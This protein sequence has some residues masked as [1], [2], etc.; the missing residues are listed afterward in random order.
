MKTDYLVL[1]RWPDLVFINKKKM[2]SREFFRSSGPYKVEVKESEKIGRYSDF[3]RELERLYHMNLPGLFNAIFWEEQQW[4]Y[5]THSWVDKRFHAF[6]KCNSVTNSNSVTA[7]AQS[8]TL[9]TA[10]TGLSPDQ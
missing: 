9:A 8:S 5:L 4:N 1:A 6:L 10:P 2:L 7:M 3:A